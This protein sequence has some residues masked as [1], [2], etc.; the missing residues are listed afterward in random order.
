MTRL[1][2]VLS[3]SAL[4]KVYFAIFHQHR[5]YGIAAWDLTSA[6]NLKLNETIQRKAIRLFNRAKLSTNLDPMRKDPRIMKTRDVRDFKVSKFIHRLVSNR[7]FE[8]FGPLFQVAAE[9]YNHKTSRTTEILHQSTEAG[10]HKKS[11]GYTGKSIWN[12]LPL[13]TR[14]LPCYSFKEQLYTNT[15]R[16]NQLY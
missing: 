15:N 1:R 11:V 9:V 5:Q 16:F 8:V 2:T 7:A 3:H 13:K 12:S 14:S 6:T 10:N 4:W